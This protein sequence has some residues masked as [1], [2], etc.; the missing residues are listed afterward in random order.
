MFISMQY[1]QH[2][3]IEMRRPMNAP[4]LETQHTPYVSVMA[5][6]IKPLVGNKKSP[7]HRDGTRLTV[8]P[9]LA[10]AVYEDARKSLE[11]RGHTV[12]HSD[13]VSLYHEH[14]KVTVTP[15]TLGDVYIDFWGIMPMKATT[16]TEYA[17]KMN[18]RQ[19]VEMMDGM[20]LSTFIELFLRNFENSTDCVSVAQL[21]NRFC[22]VLIPLTTFRVKTPVLCDATY[23]AIHAADRVTRTFGELVPPILE[24]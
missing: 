8:S 7:L 12:S 4:P 1:A 3:L 23:R 20:S 10:S 14:A 21:C 17:M 11:C 19:W 18:E 9:H 2:I 16:L 6:R 5:R 22:F 13:I 15:E 24:I